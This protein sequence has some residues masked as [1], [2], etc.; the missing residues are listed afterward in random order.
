MALAREI[1]RALEDVVGER[2][3]SED[4]GI[5]ETYRC[6]TSQSQAHYGPYDEKTPLPQAVI[7]PGSTEEVQN[8]VRICNKYK[9]EFKASTT[10]WAVM[11]YIGSDYAIQLDMRRMRNIEIDE[12]NMIAIV[13]PYAIGAVIQAEAMK[14]GLNL[15]IPGVGCSSSVVASTSSWVGFG[16]ASISM[17]CATENMLGVE[18]VLPNGDIL[19]TGSAGA[20]SGWFCGEG[21]GP[22][23]RSVLRGFQGT[24][25]EMGVCTKVAIRLHPWPGPTYL[26]SEGTIPAYRAV[27]PDNFKGYT[28]CFPSWEAYANAVALL[29]ESD[30]P[31]IGHRQYNMFGRNLKGA[32]IKILNDP[33]KQ[34]CDL[35]ELTQ[36][37]EIARQTEE[38]KI[39]IQI[40]IAGM[41][42]R[43]MEYKEKALDKILEDTGGWKASMMLDPDIAAWNLLYLIRLGHKNLNFTLCGGYEGNFGLSPNVF[44]STSLMEEAAALKRK[45]ELETPYI[46]ATGGDSDMGGLSIIGGGGVTGWEFFTNFDAYDKESVEGTCKFFDDTQR[47]MKEKGLGVDMG[48][49][50][51]DARKPDGY[52]FTQ[53][54]Q[55]QM[56]LN[57]PQPLIAAYQWKIREAFNPNRLGGSYYRTLT[58]DKLKEEE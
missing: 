42:K 18:W 27:L 10:F 3:I 22:G 17:G 52:Y 39:D 19:R 45:W 14:V 23:T 13:E 4:R 6:I 8:I 5:L 1:Y 30:V 58:P 33:D 38:M 46:A 29:H 25:G 11:G 26:P 24:V 47:W 37:P 57:L 54:E 9:I 48:R 28:L 55:D 35:P 21:P 32:M 56:L 34:L 44:V 16:P 7:L 53:K 50:N 20:G 36:D 49:W 31:Y 40:I 43:D 12:R 41:T 2:N 15:N 51:A